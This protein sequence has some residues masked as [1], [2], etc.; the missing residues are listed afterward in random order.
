MAC[1]L[2]LAVLGCNRVT[3]RQ[4]DGPGLWDDW[5][6]S[7]AHMDALSPRTVQTLRRWDLE[8]LSRRDPVEAFVRLQGMVT[9]DPRPELLFAL[10]EMGYLLGKQAEKE[11]R[12]DACVFYYFS[13]GYAYHYLFDPPA[14]G[15][16]GATPPKGDLA[17]RLAEVDGTARSVFDPRFRL[18]CNL[19]N[20]GL[21]ELIRSAQNDGQLEAR[22]HL[23]LR[24]PKKKSCTLQV[25]HFGFAWRPEEFGKLLL[26]ADY[27]AVG[28]DNQYRTFGLG[29]P[30]IGVRRAD[31]GAPGNAYY[32][33]EVS[34]PVT[35]FYH[36]EGSLDDL[37]NGRAGWLGLYNPLAVQG[38]AVRGSAVPLESD[39]TT[40]L[41]YFLS[42]IPLA[43]VGLT[44]F[45]HADRLEPKTGIYLVEPYQPGK[46]PVL[47]VHG[48][49][50][51]PL[52]WS[53]LFN[54]L[55]ADPELRRRYQFWFYLYP[56]GAPYL[57]SAA[58]L[59][60]ALARLRADFDPEHRDPALDRL[61]CVG[62]SMGGL[63]SQL[64][65]VDSGDDFW[66]PVSPEPFVLVKA[67]PETRAELARVFF[68]HQQP[69]VR[70]VVFLGTPHRGSRLS[71]SPL[72]RLADKLVHLP[73]NLL[74]SAQ[75]LTRENPHAWLRE[76]PT[77][78]D[79]LAPGNPTLEALA[80]RPPPVGVHYHS[81]IGDAP[82]SSLLRELALVLGQ[83]KER[84]DGVVPYW[85]AHLNS[86]ESEVVVPADHLNVHRHPLAVREVRRILIEHLKDCQS[87]NPVRLVGG[88]QPEK[89]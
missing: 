15:A 53:A 3:V 55:R 57:E 20:T 76:I 68:F 35:A 64:L 19:Y 85:S 47:L 22:H 31:P 84:G 14:L 27:E 72:G 50:S 83:G 1:A 26:A 54:D 36:F 30:L 86:A 7:V 44:G 79:L 59:R 69:G 38:L 13:A 56:T 21:A 52:T 34:F 8:P 46:I 61:V 51:S 81:I 29:V 40:P 32:P 49:L 65:T 42:R 23:K 28:L 12:P 18:A 9:K 58:D 2:C 25:K 89:R 78:V 66:K 6:A 33:P 11:H 43:R 80:E 63:V 88:V 37:Q 82:R 71:P 17:A 48:L 74:E 4:G 70:R 16:E 73:R 60:D 87:Q 77:S 5:R 62:H 41:A 39:L 24:T 67:E 10:A 75:D 45:L